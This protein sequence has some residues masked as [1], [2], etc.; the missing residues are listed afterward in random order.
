MGSIPASHTTIHR[1][2]VC[3]CTTMKLPWPGSCINH[4]AAGRWGAPPPVLWSPV[5]TSVFTLQGSL[6]TLSVWT[7]RWA[8]R[9]NQTLGQ[10]WITR[11]DLCS[12]AVIEGGCGFFSG[13]VLDSGGNQ[14]WPSSLYF[15]WHCALAGS[16][17]DSEGR[18]S[19]AELHSKVFSA[20]RSSSFLFP[21]QLNPG[22]SSAL[23]IYL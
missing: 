15:L 22:L 7:Q 11:N 6:L 3:L 20:F 12:A 2:S 4:G 23:Y 17:W 16:S 18:Q 5:N 14:L 9:W 19:L 1:V 8:C 13:S 10:L 21:S